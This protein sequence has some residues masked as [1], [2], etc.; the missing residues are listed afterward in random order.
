VHLPDQQLSGGICADSA[1]FEVA[2]VFALHADV[3]E[4]ADGRTGGGLKPVRCEPATKFKNC[5]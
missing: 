3:K 1:I 4:R 5:F 2:F